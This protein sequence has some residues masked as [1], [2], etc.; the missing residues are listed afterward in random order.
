MKKTL[1]LWL[2]G[3]LLVVGQVYGQARTVTG[4]VTDA[5]SVY[6]LIGV[7]VTIKGTTVG[8][9]TDLDGTYTIEA[10]DANAILVFSYMGY[11]SIE[12]Q[13]NASLI[14]VALSED[15]EMLDEVVVTA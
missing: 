14:G 9:T 15:A 3:L 8:T 7:N 11:T 6:P 12:K 4:T 13:A 5:Q 2:L 1:S 10:P